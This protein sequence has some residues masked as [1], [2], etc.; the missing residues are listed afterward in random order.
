MTVRR[1][2]VLKDGRLTELP[3]ADSLPGVGAPTV[4]VPVYMQTTDPLPGT[5]YIWFKTD[6][7][8]KVI[9]I[10]KGT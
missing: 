8:G 7:T 1:P 2:L 5:P 10:M 9:D 6:V 3:Q 4:G